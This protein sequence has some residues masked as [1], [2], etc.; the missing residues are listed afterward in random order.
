MFGTPLPALYR[1][2]VPYLLIYLLALAII[3]YVPSV[4]LAPLSWFR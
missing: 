2:V 3:T 4:T 1:G